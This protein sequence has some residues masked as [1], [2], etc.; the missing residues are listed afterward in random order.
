[1]TVRPNFVLRSA[2]RGIRP[3]LRKEGNMGNQ[4][5]S[6]RSLAAGAA[7]AVPAIAIASAAPAMALSAGVQGSI[8][9]LFYGDGT[10]NT[11]THSMYLGVTTT[12]GIIPK[13]TV[14]SWT[15]CVTGGGSGTGGTNEYPT[16]N[17]SANGSWTLTLSGT[18]GGGSAR[19]RLFHRDPHDVGRLQHRSRSRRD[20]VRGGA[21]LE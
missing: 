17:Y 4:G 18:S 3:A 15:V 19:Q 1:M 13:D 16:T 5:V 21:G 20:V 14:I 11:Q 10:I 9:R 2:H 8:C 12:N 6:R 7:W